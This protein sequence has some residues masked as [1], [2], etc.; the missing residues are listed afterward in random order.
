MSRR[1]RK[2]WAAMIALDLMVAACLAVG[3]YT[4]GHWALVAAG[5]MPA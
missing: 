5:V 1:T 2:R 4:V 3:S